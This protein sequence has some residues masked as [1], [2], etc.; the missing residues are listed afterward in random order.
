MAYT[1]T[2]KDDGIYVLCFFSPG[3]RKSKVRRSKSRYKMLEA[4]EQDSLEL[5]PQRVGE[6]QRD[7]DRHTQTDT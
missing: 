1:T 4:D 5:Q 2:P 3:R 7:T 6:T